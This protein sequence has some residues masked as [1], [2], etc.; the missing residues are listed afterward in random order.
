MEVEFPAGE[1]LLRV[2]PVKFV[3]LSEPGHAMTKVMIACMFA[4][5]LDICFF[6]G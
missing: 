4:L 6:T 2:E 1:I 3:V 5:I